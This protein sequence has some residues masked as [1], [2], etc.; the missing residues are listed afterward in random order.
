MDDQAET[1]RSSQGEACHVS[2]MIL[3]VLVGKPTRFRVLVDVD[4]P[5]L[6]VGPGTGLA[7]FLAALQAFTNRRL[8]GENQGKLVFLHEIL[9]VFR[10]ERCSFVVRMS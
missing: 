8:H 3:Q 4:R 1:W 10:Q 2:L 7:P 9:N 5:L 6:L